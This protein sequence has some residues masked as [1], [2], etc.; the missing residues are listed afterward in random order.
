MRERSPDARC[1]TGPS[2]RGRHRARPRD[3]RTGRRPRSRRHPAVGSRRRRSRHQVWDVRTVPPWPALDLRAHGGARRERRRWL[4]RLLSCSGPQR[5]SDRRPRSADACCSRRTARRGVER[6]RAGSTAARRV[7]GDLRG[8]G[9][10]RHVLESTS[11]VRDR[12]DLD[13]RS[14]SRVDASVPSAWAPPARRARSR[15]SSTRSVQASLLRPISSSTPSAPVSAT[16]S[17]LSPTVD[18]SCCSGSTR[19]PSYRFG[20][21]RSPA[22]SSRSSAH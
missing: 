20:S 14:C 17:E 19:P 2:V 11:G 9:D 13:G 18:G 21:S 3:L 15:S 7:R 6:C 12:T 16:Q 1:P 10:R 22:A 4:R 8:R 5:L